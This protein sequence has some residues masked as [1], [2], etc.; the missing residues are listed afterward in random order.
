MEFSCIQRSQGHG[1]GTLG[2]KM[3]EVEK[4]SQEKR[5]EMMLWCVVACGMMYTIVAMKRVKRQL[6]KNYESMAGCEP[7]SFG[8]PDCGCSTH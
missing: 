7:M 4:L 6:K 3:F 8:T 1:G 2:Y 5:M